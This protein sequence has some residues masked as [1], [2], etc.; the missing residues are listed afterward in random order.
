MVTGAGAS[1]GSFGKVEVKKNEL[2]T[3]SL[4]ITDNIDKFANYS[5]IKAQILNED[6]LKED[7]EFIIYNSTDFDTTSVLSETTVPGS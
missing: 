2:T 1:S 4:K 6:Y 7:S 5:S 3:L